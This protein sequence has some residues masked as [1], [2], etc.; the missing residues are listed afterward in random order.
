M[1]FEKISC[2]SNVLLKSMPKRIVVNMEQLVRE[3]DGIEATQLAEI[4]RG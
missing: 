1:A 3:P 4:E 2:S